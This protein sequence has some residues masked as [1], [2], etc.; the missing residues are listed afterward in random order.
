VLSPPQI[1]VEQDHTHT[2]KNLLFLKE[3]MTGA[4]QQTDPWNGGG[5][6]N[7]K[8]WNIKYPVRLFQA[9]RRPR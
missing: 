1:V 8:T 7:I 9:G 5:F 4:L 3:L 2:K 6:Q